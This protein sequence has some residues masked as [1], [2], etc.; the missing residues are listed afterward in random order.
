MDKKPIQEEEN[1][2]QE[3]N[4]ARMIRARYKDTEEP[5]P[6]IVKGKFWDNFWYHH[7]WAVILVGAFIVIGIILG[8]QIAGKVN[9]DI[10]V[11]YAGPDYIS[12]NQNGKVT[13]VLEEIMD[14][15]DESGDKD[16]VLNDMVF[17]S[18]AQLN[19]VESIAEAMSED[20]ALDRQSNAQTE[21]Q[22]M[23]EVMAGDTL[24]CILA[25]DQYKM[26]LSG[27]GFTPLSEIFDEI[28]EGAVDEYGIRFSET[29]FCEFYSDAQI[30]PED[31]VIALRRISTMNQ[32][33][34]KSRME[35]MLANHEDL[36]KKIVLFEFPEGYVPAGDAE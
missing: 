13:A 35:E 14:D 11:L 21:Q 12:V 3:S 28:P 26:V 18:Q 15:Y 1:E 24:L 20:I 27:G 29:K 7:K 9:V 5:E 23:Y 30:F 2:L 34:N 16:A 36:F 8:I 10:Y 25:E 6:V 4:R 31:A 19:E 33:R 17:M 22:F 32:I